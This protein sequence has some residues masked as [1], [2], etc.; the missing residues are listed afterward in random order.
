MKLVSATWLGRLVRQDA[1]SPVSFVLVAGF[2]GFVFMVCQL[3]GLREATTF[4]SGTAAG[5]EF[6]GTLCFGVIYLLAYFGM[7]L[8]A[9]IFLIAAAL[10]ACWRRFRARPKDSP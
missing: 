2:F 3:A 5:G 6:A 4:L 9:P 10:L 7:V 8:V 1:F